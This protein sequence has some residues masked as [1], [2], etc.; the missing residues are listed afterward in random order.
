LQ[1]QAPRDSHGGKFQ[2]SP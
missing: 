1:L 2:A